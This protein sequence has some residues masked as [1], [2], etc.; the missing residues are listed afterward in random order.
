MKA[1]PSLL[2]WQSALLFLIA[3]AFPIQIM[4]L[5]GH[6]PFEWHAIASKLAPMNWIVIGLSLLSS[7][8]AWRASPALLVLLPI[9]SGSVVYNNWIVAAA[10][11]N[12]NWRVAMGSAIAAVAVLCLP[13]LRKSVRG[14]LLAPQR[15]WWLTPKRHSICIPVRL[16]LHLP[17]GSTE[18]L[19]MT[20]DLSEGGAFIPLEMM[21]PTHEN[22]SQELPPV[23]RIGTQCYVSLP[24]RG[25]NRVSCRA[26]VVRHASSNGRYPGGI[27][28]RFLGLGWRARS[29]LEGYIGYRTS[30]E[31][32]RRP[33]MN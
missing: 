4:L 9:L 17:Q 29:A 13:V 30:Q 8:L 7:I 22:G 28:I 3:A 12:Y 6:S 23:I 25:L 33:T 21:A 15:R 1:R 16:K 26:E 5:F 10:S 14:L 11:L 18:Y 19:A 24:L 20:F 31:V 2:L 32:T 27:G